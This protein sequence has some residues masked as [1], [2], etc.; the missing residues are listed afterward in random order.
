MNKTLITLDDYKL[1]AGISS[2]EREDQILAIIK[3]VSEL[4]K[5][6]CGRKFVD[7]YDRY[8]AEFL[9]IIE[10]ANEPGYYF[11]KEFPINAVDSV[12]VS[13]DKGF[14]YTKFV[15]FALDRTKDG[16]YIS[17]DGYTGI[18]AY[19][20]TYRG[21]YSSV[22]E[23][24]KLACLDLVDYYYRGESVPRKTS[25]NSVQEYITTSD[26]PSHI[27]RVLDLYRVL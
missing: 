19:K 2:T 17:G 13:Y 25:G 10:Y 5:T 7:N 26:F 15:D 1:Y 27:K 24:L 8:V 16:I 21:G 9:P 6:Y 14:T 3:R 11:P 20:I 4:I 12:Q 23:D 18:N 22:P